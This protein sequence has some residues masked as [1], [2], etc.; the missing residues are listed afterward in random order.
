V[1]DRLQRLLGGDDLLRLR[2]RLREAFERSP[3]PASVSL[4]DPSEAERVAV[5]DLLGRRLPRGSV[6]T[7]RVADVER[8]LRH[9]GAA[10]DLPTALSLLDGPLRDRRSERA[11]DQARWEA[12]LSRLDGVV[13]ARPELAPWRDRLAG[14]LLRRSA[15]DA[16]S[17]AQLTDTAAAVLDRLPAHD[18]PRGVLAREITGD[19]HAL[20]NDRVLTT[21]VMA[22]VQALTGADV[23]D[24]ASRRAAWLSVGV[25][26]GDVTAPVLT[27]GLPGEPRSA[28]GRALAVWRDAGQP[29]H[30]SLRQLERDPPELDLSRQ[31]V[32]VCENPVVVAAAADALG[33][34]CRPLVCLNGQPAGAARLLLT[35]LADNGVTLR[36]HADFDWGGVTIVN[37]VLRRLGGCPWR[38]DE[39]SYRAAAEPGAGAALTDRPVETPWDP[40]L[41]AA[42][43]T[44]RVRVEEEAVLDVLL[45]DLA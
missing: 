4:R 2:S 9:S 24:A 17:A 42:M 27:L 45:T 41:A 13:E 12:A 44:L 37:G 21:L 26:T 30:L 22:A 33:A 1:T 43:R 34:A 20:D 19:A 32:Y 7:V 8:V 18:V 36:W 29:V 3:V 28:T 40:A 11:D 39:A 38:Y 35:L 23:D 6:L 16:A 15:G 10:P 14:G 25:L 5:A 31:P